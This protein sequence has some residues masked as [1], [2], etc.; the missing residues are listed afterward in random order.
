MGKRKTDRTDELRQAAK[1]YV[2]AEQAQNHIEQHNF[3]K[4]VAQGDIVEATS[5]GGTNN[6]ARINLREAS[7]KTMTPKGAVGA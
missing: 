5:E 3:D 7:K 4:L 6:Y 2:I 1:R